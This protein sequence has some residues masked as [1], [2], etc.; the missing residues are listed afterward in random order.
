MYTFKHRNFDRKKIFN[1][2]SNK[3]DGVSVLKHLHRRNRY[4]IIFLQ[5]KAPL[6]YQISDKSQ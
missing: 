4:N 2:Y 3:I 1:N 6:M 5:P